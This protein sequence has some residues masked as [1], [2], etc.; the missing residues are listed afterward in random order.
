M[1][2]GIVPHAIEDR[3]HV[4]AFATQKL[5]IGGGK[6]VGDTA[7]QLSK[8]HQQSMFVSRTTW[9]DFGSVC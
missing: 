4:A 6:I 8:I 7:M 2:K 5:P 9:H 3:I 1:N